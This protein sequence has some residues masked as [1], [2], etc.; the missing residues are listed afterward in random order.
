M[1]IN[2]IIRELRQHSRFPGDWVPKHGE[3]LVA[4]ESA[5]TENL[6][7]RAAVSN[8]Q[9]LV[10]E[11]AVRVVE[12]TKVSTQELVECLEVDARFAD[13]PDV[14]GSWLISK[15]MLLGK[16]VVGDEVCTRAIAGPRS[17]ILRR[18]WGYALTVHKAQG[19]EW[20]RVLV[21]DHGG[22]AHVSKQQWNYVALT[23]ARAT[24]TV[25]RLDRGSALLI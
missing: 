14:R 17:G 11:R 9:Q 5:S 25:V 12:R 22:Y 7:G 2:E 8:G 21:V 10:V 24:V 20:G 13:R 3:L 19:S 1:R 6:G 16:H 15:E 4:M 23:R 18:D